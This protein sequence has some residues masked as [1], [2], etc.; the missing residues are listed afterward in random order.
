MPA[1]RWNGDG[2]Y[3]RAKV[4]V[5]GAAVIVVG[6]LTCV[7]AIVQ[8]VSSRAS[9]DYVAPIVI[10]VVAVALIAAAMALLKSPN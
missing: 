3:L 5:L 2:P 9:G 10:L 7:F 1:P 8:V 6:V 4:V